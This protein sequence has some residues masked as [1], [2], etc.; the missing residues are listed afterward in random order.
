MSEASR[1]NLLPTGQ[2]RPVST[3][4]DPE[5]GL[6]KLRKDNSI[7]HKGNESIPIP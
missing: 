6:K 1:P 4:P 5:P 2:D 7:A 3:V